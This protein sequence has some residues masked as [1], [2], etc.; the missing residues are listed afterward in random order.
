MKKALVLF[1]ATV[2]GG[3]AFSKPITVDQARQVAVNFWNATTQY[4]ENGISFHSL[5]EANFQEISAELGVSGMYVFNALDNSG[6]VIVA[7]DDA[8]VPVLGYSTSNGI[9]GHTAMPANLRGWLDHYTEEIE[10]VQNANEEADE[11]TAEMWNELISGNVL[12]KNSGRKVVSA[13]IQTK[14]NQYAPYND[15]CPLD[16]EQHSDAGSV[17]TAMAQVMKYWGCPTTG[18]GSHS[19]SC[20]STSPTQTLSVNFA[21]TTYDWN[22]MPVGGGTSANSWNSTQKTAV[23]TLIYHCG[24]SV[25]MDYRSEGSSAFMSDITIALRNYF[26]YAHGIQYKQKS[27]Y[28]DNNWTTLLKNELDAGR[29]M[30]Y[31]GHSSGGAGGHCFV[32]DGYDASSRFH[33]NWGWNGQADGYFALSSLTPNDGNSN[34]EFSYYQEAIIGI[35]TIYTVTAE[36]ADTSMGNVTGG[37]S[38][39]C[40]SA[41]TITANP[42]YGYHFSHW[43]DGNT[44]NPRTITLTN[45]ASF[46]AYFEANQYVVTCETDDADMGNVEGGGTANYLSSLTISATANYG[47]HFDHWNDGNTNNPRNI[48]VTGN[49]NFTAYFTPNQYVISVYSGNSSQGSA[50][51][52][53]NFEYLSTHTIAATANTGYHFAQW[54]DGNTDNPRT[55]TVTGEASYT[56]QFAANQYY[57]SIIPDNTSHGYTS[58][59]GTYNYLQTATISATANTGY[60]FLHW[61]DGN[62]TNPRY[63]TVTGATELTAYFAVSLPVSIVCTGSGSGQV[64]NRTQNTGNRC[65]QT[66]Y[67]SSGFFASYDFLPDEESELTHLYVNNVDRINNVTTYNS[68]TSYYFGFTVNSATS[69]T[70]NAVFDHKNPVSIVC[71]GSGSG[72]VQKHTQNT[73]NRCGQTDYYSGGFFASYDFLPDVGS[74]LTHL[75]VNNVDYINNVTTYSTNNSN[76]F[77]FTVNSA[78]SYTVNPVFNARTYQIYTTSADATMGYVTGGGSYPAG[79]TT[80]IT[81]IPYNGYHFT[82][83][84]DGNTSNPRTITVTGNATYTAYFVS[85]GGGEDPSG[86]A[87]SIACVGVDMNNHNVVRWMPREGVSVVRYNIYREGLGGYSIVGYVLYNG[88]ADYSWV[89]DNSNTASQTYSYKISEVYSNGT[90]SDL[91]APH[92]TM[93]LQIS[94]G[95]GNTWNLSWTP[96]VG[97]NY[98]GYRIFRGTTAGSM[99]LLT[100]LSTSNTTYSDANG[101]ANSYYQI[102]VVPSSSAKSI[103]VAS[104]SNIASASTPTTYTLTVASANNAMGTATGGGTYQPGAQATITAT[105]LD[106]YRFTNWSDGSTQASRTITVTGDATYTAY[107][108]T[109]QGGETQRYV[110]TVVSN[111]PERGTVTG[112]GIY[113]EGAVITITAEPFAGYEFVQWHDGNTQDFRAITVTA[114]AT[115][116]AYFRVDGSQGIDEVSSEEVKVYAIGREIVI[117]GA[118]GNE[119]LVYDVMG[120]VVHRGCIEGSIRVNA[121]GVYVVKVGELQPRKVVVRR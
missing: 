3:L 89:D 31:G 78:T 69:Y 48:T 4:A 7:G 85:T 23:A 86:D 73:G 116:T 49:A 97:F 60:Y 44:D 66:D 99:S 11:E 75:Y 94:Q 15:L 72:Q 56:A 55:I 68:G 27:Y 18:T 17:A 76:Y 87:P 52:G 8:V 35:S 103:T 93:H 106:G 91:S 39:T 32:C 25:D 9:V 63:F 80:T 20:T 102:E 26:G 121:T 65:G 74:E 82:Q 46:T 67:Y 22:N 112:G 30:I 37:G 50:S 111:N 105:P 45:N 42:N 95:Q 6:F 13:L 10:A 108:E 120:R 62:T 96:Y 104:R 12:A 118:E 110:I 19:Y 16:G 115:Y 5:T 54:N 57:V 36:S 83:W 113:D 47:Y 33:F 40:N 38:Y 51:G 114:D 2:I 77:G 24:V 117:E 29:P 84:N 119:T 43:Q 98:D 64:Q 92:T 1:V 41:V 59:S 53:G 58:G 90:E 79:Q 107:F 34:Q 21:N 70:I 81:A 88:A 100:A 71:T 61:S 109:G 101:S 28:S 14:W